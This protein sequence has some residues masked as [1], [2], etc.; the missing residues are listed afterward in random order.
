[1]ANSIVLV[2]V[3]Q[4]IAPAPSTLQQ[5]G[6]FV[7]Q[8]GTTLAAG[9]RQLLTS[10][11]DLL[12][13][14]T[15]AATIT[16]LT[17][18]A[19]VVTAATAAPHG[20]PNG[21]TLQVIISGAVPTAYNG[22]FTA[23]STGASTFTYPLLASPGT[24]TAPGKFTVEDVSELLAMNT[25]FWAQ[26]S[27]TSVYVLELGVGDASDGVT[28]LNTYILNNP[29]FFYSYLVPRGWASEPTYPSFLAQF[30]APTAK[31][32]FYT[33]MT[34][35]N[36]TSFTPLMKC[37]KGM[38]EEPTVAAAA[39]AGTAVEFSCASQFQ[40]DLAYK[41][42]A[43]NRVT[44]NSFS[45]LFGVTPYPTP[46]NGTL[47]TQLRAANVNIVGTGAEGG[48]SDA[49]LLWGTTM[50]GNDF[51]YWYSVDWVQIQIDLQEANAVINGSNNPI[52][53]LY[54]NQSGIDRLQQ[55]ANN[56]VKQGVTFGLVLFGPVQTE[57]AGTDLDDALN[58]G[59]YDGSTV[60]NA[61]PFIA[62][63]Q[64]NPS[65][66]KVGLYSGISISQYTPNR[67]FITLVFNIN[68]T[69]FV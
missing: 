21:E 8:G 14:L 45:F 69:Q 59:T 2:N 17:W 7:S 46:G 5:T 60:V 3:S 64:E 31:T 13:I 53:P 37:V 42:S 56:V 11:A 16:T 66:F 40:H 57:F 9:V 50:D 49:I 44:P 47:F 62:Y 43:T 61:E 6:A 35:A 29:G 20:I 63:S 34:L 33:T 23:T 26:G 67:G 65:D 52:N 48:V 28:A 58:S 24:N 18:S 54:Y 12:A 1:M 22:I 38:V 10:Q 30:E 68:I 19:N 25:T 15:G 39:V 55:V 36:Y 51:T 41:P 32:Y 27:N 4:T